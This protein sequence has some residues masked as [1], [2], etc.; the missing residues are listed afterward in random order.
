ME[1]GDLQSMA[2]IISSKKP[3]PISISSGNSYVK[4]K[5]TKIKSTPT[6]VP[7]IPLKKQKDTKIAAKSPNT[8]TD[9][10]IEAES[11]SSSKY[12]KTVPLTQKDNGIGFDTTKGM[13]E[14]DF[15]R[16]YHN[17]IAN[18]GNSKVTN[19]ELPL[20]QYSELDFLYENTISSI[21]LESITNASDDTAYIEAFSAY[22]KE[23]RDALL[24]KTLNLPPDLMSK[25]DLNTNIFSLFDR[26]Y[27]VYPD[28]EL[29]GL[30]HY[31]FMTRPDLN[32]TPNSDVSSEL[33]VN[34]D[35]IRESNQFWSVFKTNPDIIRS[36]SGTGFSE[37]QFI[38]II[39]SRVESL[40]VPDYSLR[41]Y[42]IEQPYSGYTM[43][44]SSHG[45]HSTTGGQF[46]LTLR[47]TSDLSLHKLFQ[48]WTRYISDISIGKYSPRRTYINENRCD[49][50]V[51]LYDIVCAPD[52]KTILFW[53]KYVGVF[54]NM[55]PNSTLSFNRGGSVDNQMTIN[56]EYF[57]CESMDYYS[58]V[59]FNINSG[60]VDISGNIKD[61]YK[62]D[63]S[64][65]LAINGFDG[66]SRD[67]IQYI[68]NTQTKT[69][70]INVPIYGTGD[71]LYTIPYI[72]FHW[73]EKEVHK[74]FPT[75]EWL[76]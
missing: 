12:V 18:R 61:A 63:G 21:P 17:F 66:I 10:A 57:L 64:N 4:K 55:T 36:L 37:H 52:A 73:D 48:L 41:T 19:Y 2:T 30:C 54:P 45:I 58:L 23:A 3:M 49:Y 26:Y 68:N 44:I 13:T 72:K 11:T 14:A 56:F 74:R 8:T 70:Y 42:S 22:S 20:S 25:S 75:L 24:H 28:M 15:N 71:A 69:G 60:I 67:R 50:A 76:K 53:F 34:A 62:V 43:P 32:I 1:R 39:T 59:D 6:A 16:N 40:Q 38:P 46:D 31:I 47:E 51:S 29:S 7:I 9:K 5:N 27:S 35:V 33:A 65:R